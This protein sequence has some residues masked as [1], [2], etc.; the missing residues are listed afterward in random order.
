[1][2]HQLQWIDVYATVSK[3]VERGQEIEKEVDDEREKRLKNR[4]HET[5][6]TACHVSAKRTL[7]LLFINRVA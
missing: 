6:V 1:M 4:T 5:Q 3:R 2:S 7:S